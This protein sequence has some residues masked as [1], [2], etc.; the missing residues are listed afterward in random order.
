MNRLITTFDEVPP[1]LVGRSRQPPAIHIAG[2]DGVTL[3]KTCTAEV[4]RPIPMNESTKPSPGSRSARTPPSTFL[5]LHLHLS[6][7]P[8]SENPSP[9]DW[10]HPVRNLPRKPFRTSHSTTNDNRFLPAVDSLISVRSFTG[11]S[12]CLGRGPRQR[13][14]QWAVYKPARSALSTPDVN[15]S[16]QRVENF[17][18]H[19]NPDFSGPNAVLEPQSR[20]VLAYMGIE[21]PDA[22]GGRGRW[23]TFRKRRR[24]P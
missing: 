6:N 1:F 15:K 8:G 16:S 4:F 7:S 3:F 18:E 24:S 21:S 12:T 11:T 5:F 13:R 10:E 19:G 20:G 22:S 14:A 2:S 17:A 9:V 23:N